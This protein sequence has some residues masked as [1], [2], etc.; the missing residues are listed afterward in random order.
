MQPSSVRFCADVRLAAAVTPNPPNDPLALPLAAFE[1][2]LTINTTSLFVAAQQAAIGFAQLPAEASK[3]F[4]YTGN[5]LN[6]IA[7][8]APLMDLGVG[9]SASAHVVH[10]ASLAYKERGFK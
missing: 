4:I 10:A 5:A 8:I 9:K 1:K 6:T 3:T 2:D 7:P